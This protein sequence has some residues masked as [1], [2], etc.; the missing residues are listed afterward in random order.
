MRDH[1]SL[2]VIGARFDLFFFI[3]GYFTWKEGSHSLIRLGCVVVGLVWGSRWQ[4]PL[5]F[6]CA[7]TLLFIFVSI[8]M[9]WEEWVVLMLSNPRVGVVVIW[10]CLPLCIGVF[11]ERFT[12]SEVYINFGH[13]LVPL[14]GGPSL[15]RG[16]PL[17]G[18]NPWGQA[19]PWLELSSKDRTSGTF[20]VPNGIGFPKLPSTEFYLR[21]GY[22]KTTEETYRTHLNF[23]GFRVGPERGA[24][25][26]ISGT[27]QM[28]NYKVTPIPGTYGQSF[29][30][31]KCTPRHV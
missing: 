27:V 14:G 16:R 6:I 20:Y 2:R 13:A 17:R 3:L 28:G 10:C 22:L 8:S 4:I 25:I 19:L 26:N 1:F 7:L 12:L 24:Q 29:N 23:Y 18:G 15:G 21:P 30:F 11:N 31:Q 9:F 5:N